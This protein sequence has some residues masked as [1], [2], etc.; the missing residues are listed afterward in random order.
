MKSRQKEILEYLATQNEPKT[1]ITLLKMWKL[2]GNV[3]EY[4]SDCPKIHIV[5]TI[6]NG[7]EVKCSIYNRA[8]NLIKKELK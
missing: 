2:S 5:H 3:N 7:I 8:G 6:K 1:L 4:Y